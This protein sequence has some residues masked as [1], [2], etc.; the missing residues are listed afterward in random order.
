[1]ISA[2]ALDEVQSVQKET[3]ISLGHFPIDIWL[4]AELNKWMTEQIN[5]VYPEIKSGS[6][7]YFCNS[8]HAYNWDLKKHVVF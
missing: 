1:M 8:L 7:I 2:W 6:L 4:A 3:N 5:E